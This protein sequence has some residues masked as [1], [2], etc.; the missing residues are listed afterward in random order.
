MNLRPLGATGILVSPI[1]LG[2]VKLGRNQGTKYPRVYPLP[3]DAACIAL[4]EQAVRLGVNLIDTAPAYGTSEER[5]GKLLKGHRKE[6]VLFSKAGEEFEDGVSRFDFSAAGI[7]A[8][9]ERSLKKLGTDRLDGVLLHSD[10]V[11]ETVPARDEAVGEL[12]RLQKQGKIRAVGASTKTAAGGMWA[13]EVCDVVMLTLNPLEVGDA[14]AIRRAAE[15][16]VGVLIKKALNSGHLAA[17]PRT[18]PAEHALRFAFS[19]QGVTSVVVGT[20]SPQHLE[21]NVRAAERAISGA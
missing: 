14:A 19:H 9:V 21:D 15:M 2:T 4:L 3:D 1:G 10:G 8:S 18:D 6:W 17:G 13:V 12:R 16:G 11:I 20:L 7:R 5:L